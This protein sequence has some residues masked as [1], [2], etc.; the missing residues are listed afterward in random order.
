MNKEEKRKKFDKALLGRIV[1]L[2]K[3]YKA[4]F[5]GTLVLTAFLA[6]VS[7]MRP[8]IVS[9]MIDDYILKEDMPGLYRMA[10]LF[11]GVVVLAVLVRYALIYFSS[12]LGQ[13]V[14]R[15]LRQK[16][17]NHITSLRLRYFD[18]TPIGRV[19]TR[20]ISDVETINTV[21][22]QG[23]VTMLADLLGIFAVTGIMIYTSWQ[24]TLLVMSTIPLLIIAT[25]VFKEKV[26][27][28]FETVRNQVSNMNAFLQERITGMHIIQIFNAEKQE[29]HKFEKI[30]KEYTRANLDA[31]NYYAI[32]F[33]VVEIINYLALAILVYLGARYVIQDIVSLGAL[34]AFPWYINLLFRPIRMLA[35]NFNTLQMGM[36]AADRVFVELDREEHISDYGDKD[37]S[38]I[39]G[40]VEF[41][42]V[43]FSYDGENDVLKGV[44]FVLDAHKT[45]AIV[46]STG[47]GKTTIINVLARFYELRN[48][49]VMIDDQDIKTMNLDF[50][51]KRMAVVLQDVFLF[52]G[53]VFE[54]ITLRDPSI[55]LE[56]VLGASK[57]I[58]ADRYI[59]EMSDGYEHIITER[60]GNL[61]M[62]QRQ[63]IS[64]V[65]ALVINPDIL[66][67]DEATSSIDTETEEVI[68]HAI[69]KLIAK[70][71]SIIIAHRLSTIRNA[72]YI[73][74]M[75]KGE[76]LEF[77]NHDTLLLNE[78]GRY[79]ELYDMQFAEEVAV[80]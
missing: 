45:L 26:K 79:K 24:L 10:F 54:N 35:D 46:G 63:L 23:I 78:G 56:A 42:D 5:I 34:L 50:L 74:V 6:P 8:Y 14:I 72:D 28:A 29:M 49:K 22:T 43:H 70:R 68:Q 76:V 37:P 38:Q 55:S 20:T 32:F 75:D 1:G 48:G 47:S 17:F 41:K 80:I 3:P 18:Q 2:A 57:I 11:M 19:T 61:S 39:E 69:E 71:S 53:T 7:M 65:R 64:F 52:H 44:N 27:V 30:N 36:V 62:G 21:F 15:D 58:G 73:M 60:G 16:V 33:P 67:L 4:H 66:I 25:Y 59:Q 13:N 40:K 51:R 31:I 77:G 9:I 12:L